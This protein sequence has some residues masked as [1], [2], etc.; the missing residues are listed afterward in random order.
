MNWDD[1]R[2]FTAVAR[3][4]GL[5]GAARD[6]GMSAQTVGRRVAAL[7]ADVGTP[8]FVRHPSGYRLTADGRT[9]LTDAEVVEEAMARLRTNA[10]FQTGKVAGLV[11]LAGPETL[12]ADI[13]LPGLRPLLDRYPA[14]TLEVVTGIAPI[15]IARGE[16]DIA[17]RLVRPER[18]AL[19]VRQIG[20]MAHAL[21]ASPEVK[22]DRDHA[23]LV[24]WSEA[25]DLPAA[26]WLQKITGRKPDVLINSLA[27][28]Q[29]AIRAGIGI[30]VLPCFLA[31]GLTRLETPP[32]PVEPLWLVA[33][34]TDMV[35][36]RTKLVYDAIVEIIEANAN[37]L[38]AH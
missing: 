17:L 1:L 19:T 12:T 30:G 4:G 10:T 25:Y 22:V 6:L 14:L 32:A 8:L 26:R 21:Y 15:G 35:S 13:L 23:R 29:A 7:E 31:E 5:S 18:G 24:G 34:A 9:M 3:C 33:H 36:D 28:Q 20:R 38:Q 27:G 37:R 11:R 2:Y 16:A